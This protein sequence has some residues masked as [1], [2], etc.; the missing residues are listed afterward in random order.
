M[1]FIIYVDEIIIFSPVRMEND[2]IA[3]MLEYWF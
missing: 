1:T 2:N 3:I